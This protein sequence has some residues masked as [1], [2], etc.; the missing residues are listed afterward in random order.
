[1][2]FKKG[3]AARQAAHDESVKALHKRSK[4]AMEQLAG[5]RKAAAK[6]ALDSYKSMAPGT[7]AQREAVRSG[8]LNTQEL[9]DFAAEFII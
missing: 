7:S 4:T 2:A 1:M 9:K 5:A 3:S 6:E 8:K